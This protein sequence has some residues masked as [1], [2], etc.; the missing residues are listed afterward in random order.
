ME[1]W[2]RSAS[3]D[4]EATTTGGPRAS[5]F[6]RQLAPV[7]IKLRYPVVTL[8]GPRHRYH[9]FQFTVGQFVHQRSRQRAISS[10][11]CNVRAHDPS[12]RYIPRLEQDLV[13]FFHSPV[14]SA[15]CSG[16]GIRMTVDIHFYSLLRHTPYF[17]GV[18]RMDGL[19]RSIQQPSY[20]ETI[21]QDGDNF[22]NNG[23]SFPIEVE[24][25]DQPRPW[26]AVRELGVVKYEPGGDFLEDSCT[27]CFEEFEMEEEVTRLPCNHIFHEQQCPYD[28]FLF[29]LG[30]LLDKESRRRAISSV[31]VSVGA[32]GHDFRSTRRLEED[33]VA[34]SDV[35]VELALDLG[36]GIEMTFDICFRRFWSG[37]DAS[38]DEGVGRSGGFGGV[39]TLSDVV[40]EVAVMR[41]ETGGDVREE[42][43][44]ICLEEL[45]VGEEVTR[46]PCMH[47]FH[48]GCLTRWLE[49]SH[50]C[51]HAMPASADP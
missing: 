17:R 37:A 22:R 48:G 5:Q 43:C 9:C 18:V 44:M 25:R 42:S 28:Y 49:S 45:D 30:E 13:A 15:F 4:F 7:M 31:L 21:G 12:F 46:M 16:R 2:F 41:Y 8:Q 36:R 33:L 34:F 51:R 19:I 39:P 26:D 35:P 1:F 32:Y 40:E 14:V 47:A 38:F 6:C 20:D 3:W 24:G 23:E 10:L 29:T 11:L 27:I 50:L